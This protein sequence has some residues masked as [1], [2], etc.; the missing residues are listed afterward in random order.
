MEIKTV[1]N[2]VVILISLIALCCSFICICINRI[3]VSSE[4]RRCIQSWFGQCI[5]VIM[6][7]KHCPLDEK[8][9]SLLLGELSGLIEQGRFFFP[10]I[11][12]GDNFG[13]NKPAAYQGYIGKLVQLEKMR[14]GSELVHQWNSDSAFLYDEEAKKAAYELEEAIQFCRTEKAKKQAE[15][16]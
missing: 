9:K 12:I 4:Y 3:N 5:S 2:V 10:N 11:K 6:R 13:K 8:E 16:L 14:K 1:I 15:I 7:L